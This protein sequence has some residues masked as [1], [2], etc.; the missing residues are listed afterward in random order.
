MDKK[1]SEVDA[2]SNAREHGVDIQM[3]KDNLKRS[4]SERIRRHRIAL[5]MYNKLRNA[6]KL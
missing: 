2:L 3:L 5:D 6:K 1:K 4:V